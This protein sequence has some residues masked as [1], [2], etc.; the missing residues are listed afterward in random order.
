[1]ITTLSTVEMARYVSLQLERFFP[2]G[3]THDVAGV[4]DD[5]MA[6]MEVCIADVRL[7]GYSKDGAALFNHL[8]SDQYATFL[9]LASN[10]AWRGPGDVE[11]ASKLYMLNKALNGLMCMYDTIL[12]ERFLLIHTVG[13][14]LGKASYGDHFVALHDVTVGADRFKTPRIGPRVVL[15]GGCAV[16]GDTVL[17]EGV[18]VAAHALVRNVTVAPRH[19]VAGTSPNLVVRPVTRNLVEDHYFRVARE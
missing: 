15:Y 6:R 9:Y 19:V 2:D 17:G 1:M 4:V 14:L 5:A 10:S 7:P 3:R 12:P 11:L 13:M 16:L 8:H 18:A